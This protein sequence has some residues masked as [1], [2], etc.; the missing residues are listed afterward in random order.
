MLSENFLALYNEELRYL[1]EDGQRFAHTHPQVAQHLGML[2]DGVLDPFVERLLEGTAFL[3]ARIQERLNNEQPEFALQMLGRLAP[4]WYTPLPS[5]ATI[6]MTPDLTSPQWYS[7]VELPRGSKVILQDPSLH[8][9]QATFTTGRSLKI[10][11]LVIESAEC[12][13][14]PSVH[15]PQSAAVY[16]REG[17][18][19]IGLKLSTQGVASLSEL[20]FDPLHLTLAGDIVHTNQLLTTLLNDTVRIVL[21]AKTDDG[22][23]VVKT[24]MPDDLRQ[25]GLSGSEALLPCAIGELPGSRLLRE[26]FASP[27]R[28]FSVELHGLNEFLQQAGRGQSFE[29]IFVLEHRPLHL[30]GRVSDG[31]FRLF[32]T[33]VINLSKRRC[34]PV[35]ING[36]HTEYPV[37][38]DHL[39]PRMYEI[40]HLLNVTGL[41][42]D[43][44]NVPFSPLHGHASYE[45][46]ESPA[47]Y[48][49]RRRREFV[50]KNGH[51]SSQLPVDSL[52]IAF[53]PGNRKVDIDRIKALSI[54]AMVC[55]RHLIPGQLQQPH[56]Q[57]ENAL[58][59]RQIETLR[60][61]SR[62][63]G[64][65]DI[66]QAWKALQLLAN[67]PL[68]YALPEVSD[69]SLML[70]D[71]LSLFCQVHETSQYKRVT[72]LSHANIRHKFERNPL[73]GP[74]A[75][76]RGAQA[77]IDLHSSHH[78]DKGAFLFARIIHHALAEYCELGQTLQMD[79]KLDGEPFASWGAIRHV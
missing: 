72:S 69:C 6:A 73:P 9:K 16:L 68:R 51:K 57:L 40:H 7:N 41:L 11:P 32:A 29:I 79:V 17:Q 62:P 74:I 65:P 15:L 67:N 45:D 39:N 49:L 36:E 42:T 12:A 35:L 14:T 76:I 58:P 28:F 38:V 59:V 43:G 77:T 63:Q 44:G 33:P 56:F 52:F 27:S 8:T 13:T 22:R 53:S 23:P 70:R 75:W 25:G 2:A 21:W 10:Q 20:D 64:V 3:S 48:S 55:D 5:I 4:F 61:P 34:S 18:A 30:V 1:R 66:A 78:S 24:L 46:E 54:E 31:D 26:Y 37:I 47:G 71:W 50:D 19:H 60:H